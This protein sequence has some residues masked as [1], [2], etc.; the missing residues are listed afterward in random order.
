MLCNG[1]VLAALYAFATVTRGLL[2][3]KAWIDLILSG[4]KTVEL[5][6]MDCKYRDSVSSVWHVHVFL[7]LFLPLPWF[8]K[9]STYWKL[10]VIE[11][12]LWLE[13]YGRRRCARRIWADRFLCTACLCRS[14]LLQ[15]NGAM[16]PELPFALLCLL[17]YS[18]QGMD[19]AHSDW[20]G[21]WSTYILHAP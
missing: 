14:C 17:V 1:C 13:L 21:F 4:D 10:A 7:F 19:V 5:R 12:E 8:G 20:G 11:C 3:K 9:V 18:S 15:W 6:S 2:V 16:C